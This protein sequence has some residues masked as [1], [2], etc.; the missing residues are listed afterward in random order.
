M[1]LG[2]TRCFGLALYGNSILTHGYHS[3]AFGIVDVKVVDLI[4]LCSDPAVLGVNRGLSIGFGHMYHALRSCLEGE[5]YLGFW[6][7]CVVCEETKFPY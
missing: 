1:Q 7:G 6:R 5:S 4:W 2:R 3:K